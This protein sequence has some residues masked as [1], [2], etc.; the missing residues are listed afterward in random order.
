MPGTV[1]ICWPEGTD[2]LK[3]NPQLSSF[4]P[5]GA[6]IAS[7]DN[8]KPEIMLSFPMPI[9]QEVEFVGDKDDY[10]KVPIVF[11][12]LRKAPVQALLSWPDRIPRLAWDEHL[13]VFVGH[14]VRQLQVLNDAFRPQI[15]HRHGASVGDRK[16][17]TVTGR[18]D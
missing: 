3:G 12:D 13:G 15:V 6:S 5:V 16:M 7:T 4:N 1:L 10:R 9:R 18:R 8:A 17:A 2:R 11:S 14:P